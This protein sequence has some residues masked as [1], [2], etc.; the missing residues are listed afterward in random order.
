MEDFHRECRVGYHLERIRTPKP[1]DLVVREVD[2]PFEVKEHDGK[3]K[4]E[5]VKGS[6]LTHH[7]R[8]IRM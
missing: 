3:E 7:H 8:V 1:D 6:E 5:H 2:E 4:I